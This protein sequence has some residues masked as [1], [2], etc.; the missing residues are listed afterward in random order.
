MR[1]PM[2]AATDLQTLDAAA[3]SARLPS[4]TADELQVLV[5]RANREYWDLHAPTLP[6]TLYDQ[7]T[8]RLKRARPDA[9]VLQEMGPSRA[10]EPALDPDEAL[11]MSPEARFGAAVLH[12][13]P[14]LS[15]EKCYNE[16]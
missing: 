14:M 12:Q 1:A 11:R 7:L 5:R 8:E 15:L 2:T 4:F 9:L 16:Q 13:R 3:V 10:D 6:D